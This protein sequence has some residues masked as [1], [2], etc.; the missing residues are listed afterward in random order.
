MYQNNVTRGKFG[1]R[2]QSRKAKLSSTSEESLI[3]SSQQNNQGPGQVDR[4]GK[5]GRQV[6]RRDVLPGS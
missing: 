6:V 3:Q 4:M 2:Y 5:L 1:N